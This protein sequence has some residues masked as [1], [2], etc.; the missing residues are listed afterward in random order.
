MIGITIREKKMKKTILFKGSLILILASLIVLGSSSFI[1]C[2][3]E[4]ES[5]VSGS[6]TFDRTSAETL[7]IS[8]TSDK[9]IVNYNSFS[10]AQAEAVHFIQPSS[11]SIALNRVTG[12]DP[13]SLFGILTATGRIFI[14]NPNGILFG[15][16]SRVDVAGLLASTLDISNDDFLNGKYDFYK[17]G[18]GNGYIVNQGQ[19][20]SPGGYICLL[21]GAIDNQGLILADLGTVVLASG[22]KMTLALD[23]LGSISVVV[24]GPV[25]EAISGFDSALKNSGTISANGGKVILTASVLNGV[26]DY[27]INNTGLIQANNMVNRNGVI[28]LVAAGAPIINSGRLEAGKIEVNAQGTDFINKGNIITQASQGFDDLISIQAVNLLQG[29]LIM[30]DKLI[31]I[32]AEKVEVIL[33]ED[34]VTYE[35]DPPINTAPGVIIQANQ[36]K[37]FAKQFGTIDAPLVIDAA[38]IY[39]NRTQ[40]DINIL[41]SLG[42]GTSIMLRGPPDGFGAIIYNKDTNLTLEANKVTLLGQEPTYLYGNI[43]F[44]NF[45]CTIPGKEIYFESGKTYTFEGLTTIQGTPADTIKLYASELG[46]PWYISIPSN[47][48][49]IDEVLVRDSHNLNP[50]IIEVVHGGKYGSIVGWHL[51]PEWVG[52]GGFPPGDGIFWSDPLNWNPQIPPDGQDIIFN[53]TSDDTIMNM[54]GLTINSLIITSGFSGSITLAGGLNINGPYSQDSGEVNCGSFTLAVGGSFILNSGA[55]FNAQSSNISVGGNF[56]LSEAATFDPGNSLVT[57]NGGSTPTITPGGH[58]F[59]DVI[60]SNP[61]GLVGPLEAARNINVNASITVTGTDFIFVADSDYN[62]DGDFT[63][64]NGT[65]ITVATS[66]DI[67]IFGHNVILG[68]PG[69]Y[70]LNAAGSVYISASG[71]IYCIGGGASSVITGGQDVNLHASLN[72]TCGTITATGGKIYVYADNNVTV[73]Q[74]NA[75]TATT[76][77]VYLYADYDQNKTGT[78]SNNILINSPNIYLKKAQLFNIDGSFLGFLINNT[79]VLSLYSTN[80]NIT[81]AVGARISGRNNIYL[82]AT[83]D[84]TVNADI[85][86][87]NAVGGHV[88]LYADQDKDKAGQLYIGGV[89]TKIDAAYAYLQGAGFQGTGSFTI[90]GSFLGFL[91]SNTQLLSITSTAGNI[92]VTTD[93]SRTQG[94]Y[95]YGAENI[96]VGVGGPVALSV[97]SGSGK[98]YVYAA[99]G[100]SVGAI[101][102]Q[103][104]YTL[105]TFNAA[106]IYF[107]GAQNFT[108][109]LTFLNK[110]AYSGGAADVLSINALKAEVAATGDITVTTAIS[111]NTGIYLYAAGILTL[112]PLSATAITAPC[113][114]LLADNDKDGSGALNLNNKYVEA[115]K[116]Y[117]Q[118]APDGAAIMFIDAAFLGF[119]INN[120]GVLS[121]CSTNGDITVSAPI[122]RNDGVYLFAAG[123][124]TVNRTTISTND[125]IN[126]A[127]YLYADNDK[128]G[129]GSLTFITPPTIMVTA[130]YIYLQGANPTGFTLSALLPRLSNYSG[131]LGITSTAAAGTIVVD[132]Q[133][134]GLTAIYILAYGDVTLN[135][136]IAADKI[137]LYANYDKSGGGSLTLNNTATSS[138]I[139]LQS[140]DSLTANTSF[141]SHFIGNKGLA[142]TSTGGSITLTG[143]F[144]F[145]PHDWIS[146]YAAGSISL[147]AV[148]ITTIDRLYLHAGGLISFL[149]ADIF[150][151]TRID[152]YSGVGFSFLDANSRMDLGSDYSKII[153]PGYKLLVGD[154]DHWY[155]R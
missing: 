22:E 110:L 53:T 16:N 90:D 126:G 134:S 14:I 85:I 40:G 83:G 39:I 62:G 66:G 6:A 5:V 45:N 143:G 116:I 57:F 71:S 100:D 10:I 130:P 92:T 78:L 102:G 142:I 67:K 113:A 54:P 97:T 25:K 133:L 2:L 128:K 60:I 114:Y 64:A 59:Y 3:P 65:S 129:S 17:K 108:I 47:I 8:T 30:A 103:I 123:T 18:A 52:A 15:P 105:G 93:I 72:I 43:T 109:D 95:L 135:Q 155:L 34:P 140:A 150:D 28:E 82:Y 96:T 136:S 74:A 106:N 75:S 20:R 27:A 119:L 1:W 70:N 61:I 118:S 50:E 9:L 23:N 41:D 152:V 115:A 44:Y 138:Y 99:Y 13:S 33:P 26:F 125:T 19:I 38:L 29:G 31:T 98:I 144:S 107:Q 146:L 56:T 112:N 91:T 117:L 49:N 137:Y 7:T 51:D 131:G 73:A 151:N 104:S 79:G 21:S 37:I 124:L 35:G 88:Y 145:G 77:A 4:G 69:T 127:I 11:S 89:G 149:D 120:T 87:D 84:I 32:N 63:Q 141:L 48:H 122:A 81:V 36:V 86:S 147:E 111:R 132:S 76:G 55:I 42:I 148:G 139:Y 24:D 46:K 101:S 121:V 154:E 68:V 80:G 12:I 58:P 153:F 94:I